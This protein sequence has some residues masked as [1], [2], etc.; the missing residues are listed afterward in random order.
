METE[1]DKSVSQLFS[2]K[3]SKIW[4]S[5]QTEIKLTTDLKPSLLKSSA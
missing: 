2:F 1:A 4:D 5:L 3:G